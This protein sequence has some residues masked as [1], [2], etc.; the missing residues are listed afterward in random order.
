MTALLFLHSCRESI[1]NVATNTFQYIWKDVDCQDTVGTVT[2]LQSCFS[3]SRFFLTRLWFCSDTHP[4][5][6]CLEETD[7]SS[8]NKPYWSNGDITP[9]GRGWFRSWPTTQLWPARYEKNAPGEGVFWRKFLPFWE[10]QSLTSK[11]FLSEHDAWNYS[12]H[13]TETWGKINTEDGRRERYKAPGSSIMW[14]NCWMNPSWSH[15][16]SGPLAIWD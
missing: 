6:M 9:F 13:F 2:G 15:P 8:R 4:A 5:A 7:P 3:P 16:T 11:A 1:L 10:R 12:R 14:S